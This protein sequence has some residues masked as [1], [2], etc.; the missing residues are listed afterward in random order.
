MSH[1]QLS[2]DTSKKKRTSQQTTANALESLDIFL[3]DERLGPDSLPALSPRP[4]S[5]NHLPPSGV[6][7]VQL[8]RLYF[9]TIQLFVI[10]VVVSPA[11]DGSALHAI[12]APPR[13]CSVG[14]RGG[15]V[16]KVL[17]GSSFLAGAAAVV[18]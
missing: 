15:H 11:D 12:Q 9:A 1:Y 16:Q 8:R 5:P 4:Y 10:A 7:G 13:S 2:V 17:L 18:G 3:S 14:G 6:G